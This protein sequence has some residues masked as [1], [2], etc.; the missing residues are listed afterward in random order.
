MVA[1]TL[2][3]GA[4]AAP[5]VSEHPG[6]EEGLDTGLHPWTRAMSDRG[7][8]F[9]GDERTKLFLSRSDGDFAD[10]SDV[11]GADS[12]LDG[13]AIVA[14]DFDDDGDVDLFVHNIQRE[15]H[16]LFRN[17][18]N[19]ERGFLEVRLVAR[20]REPVGA[21][22]TVEGPRGPVSQVLSRGAGFISCQP[23]SVHF[24]LGEAESAR[25][26]VRW[27]GR[28]E[29]EDFGAVPTGERV[30]LVE[31][32]GQA[33]RRARSC[34][35]LADPLSPGLKVPLGHVL[36]P[37]EVVDPTGAPQRID[38]AVA[39]DGETFE[40]VFWAS[41]CRPCVAD[42][43]KHA[44]ERRSGGK[45]IVL[46]SVDVPTDRQRAQ[47]LARERAPDLPLYFLSMEDDA[48][49]QGLDIVVDLLRLP[50]PTALTIDA[51][52]TLRGVRTG[53]LE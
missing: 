23:S 30:V 17:E 33:R 32:L 3:K 12:P 2:M 18:L 49:E 28:T 37:L 1:T 19:P 51:D 6:H 40:L 46:L 7:F 27:P 11:T 4:E 50:V 15:R 10:I 29:P 14:A 47:E 26:R 21:V 20:D 34:K 25:V 22:V 45:R 52:G 24:G 39:G 48:N 41:Y 5:D 31:G 8:S 9:N 44:E 13:R 35:E 42:L 16:H 43:A 36:P 53:A 38:P